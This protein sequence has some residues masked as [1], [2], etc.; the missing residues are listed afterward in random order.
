MS[1][2]DV[3]AGGAY[4]RVY[5]KDDTKAGIKQIQQ[6]MRA[7]SQRF[8]RMGVGL[9]KLGGSLTAVFGGLITALT[10]PVTIAARIERVTTAF[11]TLTGSV[12]N[13]VRV[14]R[15]LRR[16][17]A[18]TPLEFTGLA[19]ATQTLLAYGVAN[20][21]VLKDVKALSGVSQGQAVRLDRLA[22]AFGQV[23]AKSRLYATEVRQFTESGF[24]PLSEMA[25]TSGKSM[26]QLLDEM[27]RGL[28]TFDD[29]RKA[30]NSAVSEGG[31]F[32]GNLEA[33]SKTFFGVLTKLRDNFYIAIEPIGKA[34]LPALK[35]IGS[36]LIEVT[37]SVGVFLEENKGAA[38]ALGIVGVAGSAAGVAF[39]GLGSALIFVG[40]TLAAVN[41]SILPMLKNLGLL[42]KEA[43]ETTKAITGAAT[44]GSA[45]G[46]ADLGVL[47][48]GIRGER[49]P[50]Q[51]RSLGKGESPLQALLGV[52]AGPL[53]EKEIAGESFSDVIYGM[54][55]GDREKNKKRRGLFIDRVVDAL[56]VGMGREDVLGP[57]N[58]RKRQK[59]RRRGRGRS[60]RRLAGQAISGAVSNVAAVPGKALGGIGKAFSSV[61]GGLGKVV[62]RLTPALTGIFGAITSITGVIPAVIIGVTALTAGFAYLLNR[63][64]LL[65]P[66]IEFVKDAFNSISEVVG[67]T[68][69]GIQDALAAGEY[70]LAAQIL[71]EGL[72]LA[73]LVG[74]QKAAEAAIMGF[75]YLWEGMKALA[76]A[77]RDTV[78]DIIKALPQLI[79]TALLGQK[80]IGLI[81]F[82]IISGNFG[83]G[84]FD[85]LIDGQKDKLTQL[86]D[87]A[88]AAKKEVDDANKAN[89]DREQAKLDAKA[90][91][92]KQTKAAEDARNKA[93]QDAFRKDRFRRIG[94]R[95]QGLNLSND[96]V[97][98]SNAAAR[99]RIAAL[100]D[101]VFELRAGE[102]ALKTEKMAR[103]G[104]TLANGRAI[105][106]LE[107][108]KKALEFNKEISSRIE[109]LRKETIAARFGADVA[110][111]LALAHKGATKAQLDAVAIAQNEKT[112]ITE[113]AAA[114]KSLLDASQTPE[115]ARR[116]E[117]AEKGL[118][119]AQINALIAIDRRKKAIEDEKKALEE[120]KTEADTIKDSLKSPMEKFREQVAKIRKMVA[121]GLLTRDEG[122]KAIQK[123]A[124][125]GGGSTSP[126]Q[127]LTGRS[128]ELFSAIRTITPG[129]ASTDIELLKA[130][131]QQLRV[132]RDLL[133][134]Q[135]NNNSRVGRI[136]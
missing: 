108:M 38:L 53:S 35:S 121:A 44:G 81:L 136:P 123:A 134:Q 100:R 48:Y 126:V 27:E 82:D 86:T 71:W 113:L 114:R 16:F 60:R 30:I 31:R 109:S 13:S 17:A 66:M 107:A 98:K 12:E 50:K 10:L 41:V 49:R 89:S 111:R 55:P 104:V 2:R 83:K 75:G 64:G 40:G 23:A 72:K 124:N 18:N 42:K 57:A 46:G 93:A 77:A 4:V 119:R 116:R 58:E 19:N 11:T 3:K 94:V 125:I 79:E 28:I 26:G 128:A 110:E 39:L 130:A 9:L 43:V 24:N 106:K 99:D 73:F 20:K 96:E 101:E 91:A 59:A 120:L 90:K 135:R 14:V 7:V 15:E 115:Q 47:G 6:R 118:N 74:A 32:F 56:P 131:R 36:V 87:Q 22:L 80:S 92:E 122:K 97:T 63:A 8:E 112:F 129:A 65:G 33:Q 105:L 88:A 133:K 69:G 54:K 45:T 62:G 51:K 5:M 103:E 84:S 102:T 1:S 70:M 85:K 61:F 78:V 29:V 67:Q 127:A 132:Q 25:R 76:V 34:L 117:L 95:D 21:D 68:F 52:M 37:K